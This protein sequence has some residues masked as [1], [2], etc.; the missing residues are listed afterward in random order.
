MLIGRCRCA[1]K[2][3][4]SHPLAPGACGQAS[5]LPAAE[6][7]PSLTRRGA[8]TRPGARLRPACGSQGC[9]LPKTPFELG[10]GSSGNF[11]VSLAGE[12]SSSPP[13]LGSLQPR[14]PAFLPPRPVFQPQTTTPHFQT[15]VYFCFAASVR[16]VPFAGNTLSPLLF[17][18]L[19]CPGSPGSLSPPPAPT[20]PCFHV[21]PGQDRVACDL[22]TSGAPSTKA[23]PPHTSGSV[24]GNVTIISPFL[25]HKLL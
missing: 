11:T 20:C 3:A 4:L 10:P 6:P 15:N 16:A 7:A 19:S 9:P 25:H 2:P 12:K 1:Q 5:P 13:H 22:G 14:C 21:P 24:Y 17:K 8:W 18:L 23:M